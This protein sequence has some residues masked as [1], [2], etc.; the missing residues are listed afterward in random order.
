MVAAGQSAI[1]W[2][3][4]AMAASGEGGSCGHHQVTRLGSAAFKRATRAA[5]CRALADWGDDLNPCK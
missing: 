4:M 5:T 2:L 1:P 3:T